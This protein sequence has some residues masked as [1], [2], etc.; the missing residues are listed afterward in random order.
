[1]HGSQKGFIHFLLK[2]KN[3]EI[4]GAE[5]AG[6]RIVYETKIVTQTD[7]VTFHFMEMRF[8]LCSN[9]LSR[10]C[11]LSWISR[12]SPDS[13]N[14]N[15]ALFPNIRCF[16]MPAISAALPFH[17][18]PMTLSAFTYLVLSLP[19]GLPVIMTML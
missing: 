11:W 18:C 17:S 2:R 3:K 1:M 10:C 5:N 8:H 14:C 16:D 9:P 4:A 13:S 15:F 19:V 7:F 12:C 6:G